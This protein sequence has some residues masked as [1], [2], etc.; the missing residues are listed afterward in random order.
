MIERSV[1]QKLSALNFDA[2]NNDQ[3][4]QIWKDV[5]YTVWKEYAANPIFAR[6]FVKIYCDNSFTLQYL[7][8]GLSKT[9][10]IAAIVS[11]C[12]AGEQLKQQNPHWYNNQ[13]SILAD[14]SVPTYT[15][16]C[17]DFDPMQRLKDLKH[18]GLSLDNIRLYC[19]A[20]VLLRPEHWDECVAYSQQKE[21]DFL[22][23]AL[24]VSS[25]DF[26]YFG[27]NLMYEDWPKLLSLSQW[28][29]RIEHIQEFNPYGKPSWIFELLFSNRVP[30]LFDVDM[31]RALEHMLNLFPG[32]CNEQHLTKWNDLCST[33]NFYPGVRHQLKQ[34]IEESEYHYQNKRIQSVVSAPASVTVRKI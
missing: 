27:M 2:Q 15:K 30:E 20:V 1:Q 6:D 33:L 23:E 31:A 29:Q 3:Q 7:I 9:N 17:A 18:A 11:L 16:N 25:K 32:P 28:E 26:T 24:K 8:Q 22:F 10:D 34:R 14:F 12:N 4:I 5:V 19:Y 13:S 21:Q